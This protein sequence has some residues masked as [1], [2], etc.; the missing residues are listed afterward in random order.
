MTYNLAGWGESHKKLAKKYL[1]KHSKLNPLPTDIMDWIKSARPKVEDKEREFLTCPFWIPIYE[2]PHNYQMI[3]GGRQI[4]KSTACT[5]FI[6]HAVTTQPGIQVCYV[7]HDQQS[8]S[9]FSRQKLRV[10]TFLV[11][12]ALAKYLRHPGSIG[13]VSL[14]N[15]STVYLVTDNYQYRHLEGKSPSL[16]IIDEAQYQDIEYFGRVHQTMMATKGKVKIFGIG[17]EAGSAYEKLWKETNQMEWYYDDPDWRERLLFNNRIGLRRE[18]YL[19]DVLRGRWVPQN[20]SVKLFHGYH[21]PQ[22]MV[23]T[24]P[25]TIDDAVEKYKIHPRFSIEGQKKILK[26]SEFDSHVMGGFYNS[27]HRPIT[28]KMIDDCTEHYRY[29]PM[30][31]ENEVKNLKETFDNEIT[32]AMG[33]DFGSGSSSVTAISVI[34]LWH[35]S[36][37]IQIAFI[38]KRPQENQLKQAQY[39]AELF[40]RYSCDIG[41]GDLGY[42]ANQIKIIQDGGH[43]IDTG[44]R[45]DGV[46]DGKFFGCRS[47]SDSTKPIQIFDLTTDEHGDQVGRI[48]IDKTS[49]IEY[50]VECMESV[51]YHPSFSG[52][53]TRSRAKLIIPSKNDYETGF[54]L[55]DLYGITR[56]DLQDLGKV[57]SDPRQRPRKE[58]NHPPDS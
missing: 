22:T 56:K 10:G 20:P 26:G 15:N 2:D 48:Q 44:K 54:L 3:I 13:E 46:T 36:G 55:E 18:D 38:E 19:L 49:S 11:N 14:K 16:C 50:L 42:G 58:Y 43:S 30:L 37:R 5:D 28:K 34:I 4:Y 35:K 33:V 29:L 32:V 17:G 6:A 39:I 52:E 9:S 12:P 31:R 47:T 23:A 41:V 8:L 51:V 7:T 40:G 21:I 25:L 24:I 45:F 53:K 27:P 1:E 57:I